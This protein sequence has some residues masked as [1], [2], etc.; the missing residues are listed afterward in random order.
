MSFNPSD[1]SIDNSNNNNNSNNNEGMPDNNINSNLTTTTTSSSNNSISYFIPIENKVFCSQAIS[2]NPIKWNIAGY[3]RVIKDHLINACRNNDAPENVING[4]KEVLSEWLL[5]SIIPYPDPSDD[6]LIWSSTVKPLNEAEWV[7]LDRDTSIAEASYASMGTNKSQGTNNASKSFTNN[8]MGSSNDAT[9][10]DSSSINPATT[11]NDTNS[12]SKHSS[13]NSNSS[14]NKNSV[15][16]RSSKRKKKTPR[17]IRP[18][19]HDTLA[20]NFNQPSESSSSESEVE[21]EFQTMESEVVINSQNSINSS[22]NRYKAARTSSNGVSNSRNN[23]NEKNNN[24][25]LDGS[26]TI[27]S[28]N[29]LNYSSTNNKKNSKTN[30]NE[31]NTEDHDANVGYCFR[32]AFK[33][34]GDM[35][36][37][38]LHGVVRRRDQ[39]TLN[40]NIVSPSQEYSEHYSNDAKAYMNHSN[41]NNINSFS[42]RSGSNSGSTINSDRQAS[43]STGNYNNINNELNPIPNTPAPLLFNL[44]KGNGMLIQP[45]YSLLNEY[46]SKRFNEGIFIPIEYFKV[47][48][49]NISLHLGIEPDSDISNGTIGYNKDSG[50]LTIMNIKSTAKDRVI[51]K[52]KLTTLDE[53]TIAFITGLIPI[54]CGS[55]VNK[56]ADYTNFFSECLR[57]IKLFNNAVLG[58]EYCDEIRRINNGTANKLTC[59]DPAGINMNVFQ[60]ITAKHVVKSNHAL[61]GNNNYTNNN[62]N[63]NSTSRDSASGNGTSRKIRFCHIYNRSGECSKT[64][65]S[66][67][68]RCNYPHCDAAHARVSVHPLEESNISSNKYQNNEKSRQNIKA[69]KV[70]TSTTKKEKDESQ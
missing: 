11:N 2:S 13:G 32:C 15:Q 69:E 39:L 51:N 34:S 49:S 46:I 47:V 59:T 42:G 35:V 43:N 19:D 20:N 22:S 65:C 23:S 54:A 70:S 1:M 25:Q 6:K 30:S 68:H 63:S 56:I 60:I 9:M 21:D 37:C 66:Y 41:N 31:F 3:R 10:T 33:L 17:A 64:D 40:W 4:T 16:T 36:A 44:G 29:K 50:V 18:R 62:N 7:T 58:M 53:F 57:A 26:D 5:Q 14:V 8:N 48:K 12:I 24:I 55:N 28:S 52:E 38:P 67:I 27:L 61:A 45:N